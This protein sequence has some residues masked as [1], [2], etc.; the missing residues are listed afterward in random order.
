MD[1][2][3]V[4]ELIERHDNEIKQLTEK[5]II[6]FLR[7]DAGKHRDFLESM[8]KRVVWGFGVLSAFLGAGIYFA[9]GNSVENAANQNISDYLVREQ[10]QAQLHQQIQAE[11]RVAKVAA[12]DEAREEARVAVYES[13]SKELKKVS[14]N[15][16][17]QLSTIAEKKLKE[18]ESLST[19]EI[20]KRAVAQGLKG[21]PGPP[22][23]KFLPKIMFSRSSLV[24]LKKAE[25]LS[26]NIEG[27]WDFCFISFI[28]TSQS[29][30]SFCNV[31]QSSMLDAWAME[32]FSASCAAT[33][34]RI[35]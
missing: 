22:G 23:E 12:R 29:E 19:D 32:S 25:V 30:D 9:F 34:V 17:A 16:D 8:I 10:V 33:C 21:E 20:L 6:E 28:R 24:S 5:R 31:Y 1:D 7:E 13:I 4:R 11:I 27:E 14:T 18:I 3:E 2:A 26:Q 15:L 35:E